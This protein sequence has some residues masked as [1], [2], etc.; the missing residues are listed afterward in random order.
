[1]PR[2]EHGMGASIAVNSGQIDL[3]IYTYGVSGWSGDFN[4]FVIDDADR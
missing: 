2:V 1:M 3:E 4:G